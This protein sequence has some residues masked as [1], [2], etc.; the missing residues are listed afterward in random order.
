M[1]ITRRPGCDSNVEAY[2]TAR[3]GEMINVKG[4]PWPRTVS[5]REIAS[6]DRSIHTRLEHP[7]S[8]D[9]PSMVVDRSDLGDPGKM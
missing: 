4:G 7:L 5:G 3:L 6:S 2:P 8:M 1:V 9:P